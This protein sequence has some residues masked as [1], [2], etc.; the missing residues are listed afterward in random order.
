MALRPELRA[1]LMMLPANEREEL[2]DLLYESLDD[3]A[4]DPEWQQSWRHEIERRIVDVS[5]GRVELIDAD[6]VHDAMR[7]E[8]RA[9]RR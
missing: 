2:A 7:E 6:Q 3:G 9:L 5:S 4:S 1:E 8:L